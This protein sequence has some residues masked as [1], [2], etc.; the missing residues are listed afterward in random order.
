MILDGIPQY[1][2]MTVLLEKDKKNYCVNSI[3][4]TVIMQH[5]L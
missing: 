3:E 5:T 4:F 1:Q 2:V